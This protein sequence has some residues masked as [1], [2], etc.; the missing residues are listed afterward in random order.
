[1]FKG[2][3]G[4]YIAYLAM[5]LLLLLLIFAV[6]YVAGLSVYLLVPTIIALGTA[7]FFIVFR[8]SHRFGEHGMMKFFAKR[9]LPHH[10]KFRSRRLFTQLKQ[11]NHD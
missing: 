2:L 4:Q 8:L 1:M 6:G 9:S 10:L 11:N 7:I 3:K 5:G